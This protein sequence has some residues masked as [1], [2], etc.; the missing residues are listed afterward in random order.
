MEELLKKAIKKDLIITILG[1]G[2]IGLPTAIAFAKAGFTVK[3]FDVNRK[4]IETLKAGHIH[5]VEPSLQEAFEEALK[6]GRLIPTDKLEKSDVFIISVPTPFKKN[7]EEK[8][9]DLS[10]VESASKEVAT[11]LE[12]NNLVILESTVPPMTTKLMTDIL[13]RESGISRDKFMS[14]H[15]PERV[16]PG[17]ILYE[18]EHNDRIIGA[19]RREAG[20]YTKVIYDAMVKE[21]TCYITD[22]ITAEMCKLVENTFRDVNIAFANEL[23]VIC[24][25]LGIDVFELIKLANKHPRVNILTPGAGVGG[26]CLAVDPWFI[27]EKFPKE[28]NVI[29][30][31]RLINDFKPRFI[32]NKVDEILKGNKALTVGVLGLAYKPDIDDLRESPAMEIA[33]ILRDKGY[34]VVACEP[35]V[36]TQEVNGF[37]LYS[38]D[39]ILEKSDYLVLAQGHKEFKERIEVLRSKKI[40]DCL[41][42][43]N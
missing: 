41:G 8:I 37:G 6:S 35:N 39:E 36:N 25:K 32:V 4:V 27:V 2:Y 22:D 12:E 10:Y 29:R 34:K 43:L 1:M 3:G 7:H 16:L 15:C 19:E 23:S 31:A 28:A 20:E 18:L 30:E 21:G 40:Y 11:V 14:V 33:E 42:L 17:R 13:E 38:F 5:I 9:A 24:D 26:H